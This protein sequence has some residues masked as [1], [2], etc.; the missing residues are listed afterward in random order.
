[1]SLSMKF[2]TCFITFILL[3]SSFSLIFINSDIVKAEDPFGDDFD[4]FGLLGGFFD[5]V[6]SP[7]PYRF[8]G[9]YYVNETINITGDIVFSIYFSST[10]LQQLGEK[11]RDKVNVSMHYLGYDGESAVQIEN[12]SATIT[13]ETDLS[14]DIV[15]KYNVELKNIS[16]TFYEGDYLIFSIEL[17]QTEKPLAKL[18]E[19]RFEKKIKNR[20][21]TIANLMNKSENPELS[22]IGGLLKSIILNLEDYGIDPSDIADLANSLLSSSFYYGSE[23]YKSSVFL[24]VSNSEDNKTLYFHNVPDLNL[25]FGFGTIKTANETAPTADVDSAW[26]PI[27]IS[28]EGEFDP[29]SEEFEW[30]NWFT[31]WLFYAMG[32]IPDQD[33]EF[34]T[35]Y[36]NNENK[37]VTTEPGGDT[38]RFKLSGEPTTWEGISFDRNKIITNATAELYIHYPRLLTIFKKVYIN[39]SLFDETEN[40]TIASEE[41]K[42]DRTTL[43]EF[44]S[45]GPDSPT[46]FEFEDATEKEIGHNHDISLKVSANIGGLINLRTV[47]LL[48]N[49]I[50]YPSALILTIDETDNIKIAGDFE[51]K[52]V[53]PNG[54]AEYILNITSKY[55]DTINIEVGGNNSE[56]NWNI[57]YLKS[58]DIEK[59]GTATIHVFV[60]STKNTSD[61]YGDE[62]N[63]YFNVTGKT[64][65]DSKDSTV[66][67]STYA[68]DYE[69]EAIGPK[70][71][72]IKHGTEGKYRFKIRNRNNG[73]LMDT[74]EINVTSE[75]DWEITSPSYIYN[76]EV[77]VLNEA[78]AMLNVTVSVPEFTE[79][80]SDKLTIKLL[81][82]EAD[83]HDKEYIKTIEVTTIVILPN[84]FEHILNFFDGVAEDLGLDEALG[85]YAGA[86][87]LLIIIFFILIILIF[88][89]YL[90]KRKFVD[91]ICVNRIREINP[92]EEVDFDITLQNTTKKK[93]LTYEINAE[94]ESEGFDVSLDVEKVIVQPKESNKIVLNV[95]PN[96][97]IKS[98]DWAEIIVKVKVVEKHKT[99]KISAVVTI[100]DG[101]TKVK[102]TGV[103]H[104][105]RIF[106]KGDRVETSFRLRN[107]GN[108]SANNIKVILYINGEEKNKVEDITIPRGGYAEIEIPWIAVKGKNEVNIV[109]K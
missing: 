31:I 99:E 18:I 94:T 15:K 56:G 12:A 100:I 4:L 82:K 58:V 106:K 44:I 33:E 96:D 108:V 35:Y 19:N 39:V 16:Q 28:G 68:V 69:I 10:L 81:S 38:T 87:L 85:S 43:L 102:I 90:L 52:R 83:I 64:G 30:L 26:P 76:L 8:V 21:I 50:S 54:S 36:L 45:R 71:K 9:A 89:V 73:F 66:K 98:D 5:D 74:Y 24:P 6:L 7:H 80:C 95:K 59:K 2:R 103:M 3:T 40:K 37:L 78:E 105:P 65:F 93:T 62:I 49:S 70:E 32:D 29:E 86:F 60:N 61:A 46:I 79:V 75:N 97:D 1:M 84:F 41:K 72:K 17:M 92:E 67:V 47:K 77:Y 23:S 91:I 88:I 48:C 107:V 20:L 42:L 11:Y 22:A 27:L 57:E 109:V 51:D 63:L 34:I 13:L 14:E 101:E 25:D 55:E 53:I 104:W